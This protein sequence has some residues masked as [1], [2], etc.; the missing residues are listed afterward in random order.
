MLSDFVH[1][2]GIAEEYDVAGLTEESFKTACRFLDSYLDS[3][4]ELMSFLHET[5]HG[6]LAPYTQFTLRFFAEN[7]EKLHKKTAFRKLL[8]QQPK[9]KDG[10]MD[11]VKAE[12]QTRELDMIKLFGPIKIQEKVRD[13][14]MKDT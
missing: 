13:G 9:L 5:Y 10:I 2:A 12:T 11:F 1:L 6:G 4:D 7:L 8:A 3:P 14:R